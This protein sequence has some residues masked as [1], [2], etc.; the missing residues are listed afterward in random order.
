MLCGAALVAACASDTSATAQ[1]EARAK[2]T[3]AAAEKTALATVTGGI[4]KGGG[5]EEEDGKLLWSFDIGAAGSTAVKEVNVDALTGAIVP[6]VAEA[7]QANQKDEQDEKDEKDGKARAASA[8]LPAAKVPAGVVQAYQ[9][10]FPGDRQVEWKLKSDGNYEAEFVL[11][12]VDIAA[13]FSPAGRWLETETTIPA[14]ELPKAVA[15]AIARDFPGYRVIETQRLDD[16][17]HRLL[18]EVHLEN[19]TE[20]LKT[21]FEPGG[22]LVSRSAK[23]K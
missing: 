14:T 8:S 5:I 12:G 9:S 15:S 2:V 20:V 10:E 3:R 23:P 16:A 4:V 18:L 7:K 19:S 11:K 22:K 6:E 21:Q 1:L 13:K 17:N